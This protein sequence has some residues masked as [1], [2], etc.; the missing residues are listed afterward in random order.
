M[1]PT[2]K[3]A[4]DVHL[5]NPNPLR[6]GAGADEGAALA[7]GIAGAVLVVA[8]VGAAI[9]VGAT[10]VVA[11]AVLADLNFLSCMTTFD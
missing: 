2:G 4:T 6:T 8:A 5:H 7:A 11:I 1:I 3:V 9:A 10:A